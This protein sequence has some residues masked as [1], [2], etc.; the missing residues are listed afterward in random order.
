MALTGNM[1]YVSQGSGIRDDTGISVILSVS[2]QNKTERERRQQHII[3]RQH[4]G[5]GQKSS[6]K[7]LDKIS[8]A[9]IG[10][11]SQNSR[12]RRQTEEIS[13]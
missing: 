12:K 8:S 7:P 5:G 2:V 11:P 6:T 1:L 4:S 9:I 3:Q 13:Q 10:P